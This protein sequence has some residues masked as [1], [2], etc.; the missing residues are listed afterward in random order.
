MI[1]VVVRKKSGKRRPAA[2]ATPAH[3]KKTPAQKHGERAV[4]SH[5]KT[6]R[7]G[8]KQREK[9]KK[10]MHEYS[11]GGLRSGSKAGP[12]VKSKKQALAIGYS[13]A[14]RANKKKK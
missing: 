4:K 11:K 7:K 2:K 10:V 12:R 8:L 13:E 5:A 9:I 14:R 1:D 3:A 6:S